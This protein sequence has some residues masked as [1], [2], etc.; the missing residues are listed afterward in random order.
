MPTAMPRPTTTTATPAPSITLET[1][2]TVSLKSASLTSGTLNQNEVGLAAPLVLR[3]RRA[4]R[5]WYTPPHRHVLS[6]PRQLAR[7]EMLGPPRR[8]ARGPRPRGDRA[9]PTLAR[10]GRRILGAHR[11]G[12]EGPRGSPWPSGGRRSLG[13]LG[14]RGAD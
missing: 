3:R 9:G 7:W 12:A 4:R 14:V 1:T 10:P 11:T 8:A 2:S 5:L 6:P 13:E